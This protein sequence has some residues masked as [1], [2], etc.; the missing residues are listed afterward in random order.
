ME[1]NP[2][3][4]GKGH[5]H[6]RLESRTSIPARPAIGTVRQQFCILGAMMTPTDFD[7][8][9]FG[10]GRHRRAY[11]FL[12][13]HPVHEEGVSGVRF[14]VWAPNA[15][16]VS[17][18]GDFNSW[19]TGASSLEPVGDSGIWQGFVAGAGPGDRYK[20]GIR[21]RGGTTWLE[22]ADPYGRAAE[23]RPRTASV[24]ADIASFQWSDERWL[25][26]RRET[27]WQSAAVSIYEVHLGSWRRDPSAPGRFL[28]YRELAEQL[29]AYVA[30]MGYTHVELMPI[31]EYPLDQSWGY[32][33]TGYYAPT[34]R[35]GEPGDFMYF[36]DRCHAAGLGVI[37]DWVPA[38]FPRDAHGLARFDSTHLYEHAD[39]RQGEHPDWGTLIFNYGRSEVR[40]FLISNAHFWVDEYHIDGLRIDAVASML[41]LDYS[42][43]P[44]QWVPNRYG[45][46][47]N[48][49]A[50]DFL[51]ELNQS[52]HETFPGALTFAEEST[53][54]P[55]VTGSVPEGGLGF[56]FKWNMGWMHDTLAYMERDPI[57]R[58]FHH[59]ELTFSL[60]YAFSEHFV[61]PLSHD[62]V[63]HLKHSLLDKM[64]GD[65]WQKFA[66]LRLLFGYMFGHPGKKLQFMG[67][68]FGQWREWSH[69]RSLDWNLVEMAGPEGDFHR[70]LQLFFHDLNTLYRTHMA[71]H[72][73]DY[74]WSGFEWIDFS[75]ADASVIAFERR[76]ANRGEAL[77]FVCNFTPVVRHDYRLGLA[78]SGHYRELL[79]SDAATYG[80]SGVGNL[81]A[82][83]AQAVPWHG[84][85]FS[86]GFTLP[87]LGLF[88]LQADE[89]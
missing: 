74:D 5:A 42:R 77:I 37:L 22:K 10:A 38:H 36:V 52:L 27:D 35:F 29:P 23:A 81:G 59:N 54:W 40:T 85:P 18:L 34:A 60:M 8:Y 71:L 46:R 48:L 68:E 47:E 2:G 33:V 41:Y 45:G 51:R 15:E 13:A 44:G 6:L 7:L 78:R 63:V 17:V 49:E 30:G 21:P 26:A 86:A 84:H 69:E 73:V 70:G 32:Q 76:S 31:S 53:A 4:S 67:G 25:A 43:Q 82:V 19:R 62:E 12:G 89:G 39:P 1:K 57:Y 80:G 87:P 50:I 20:Y 61:L 3:C 56:D 9:L 55:R 88:V 72:E 24:I 64:P 58:H 16:D 14:A 79:N 75:D 83:D 11:D 65:M 66:N 28:S